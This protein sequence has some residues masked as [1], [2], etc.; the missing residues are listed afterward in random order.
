MTPATATPSRLSAPAFLRP[1]ALVAAPGPLRLRTLVNL[2][3]LAVA[4]QLLALLIVA[5]GFG[6]DFPLA[7]SLAVVAVSVW[8]NTFLSIRHRSARRLS[9]RAAAG[10]LAYDMLQLSA[11][12]FLTGGLENPFAL[13]FLVPPT[14]S[15]TI[16]SLRAT[17]ALGAL[18]IACVTLLAF[19]HLPLPWHGVPPLRL[20]WL[21]VAGIWTALVLGIIF[22]AGYAWRVAAEARRMS[23][24]LIAAQDALARELRLSAL[25]GLAAAAAHE[26]GTPLATISVVAKELQRELPESGPLAEDLRLLREQ[27]ERCRA[28]LARLARAPDQDGA[29][30]TASLAVLIEETAAPHRGRG[31]TIEIETAPAEPA[32]GGEPQ[33]PRAPELLHGLGNLIENAVDF[34]RRR[35]VLR[36]SWDRQ[37][38]RLDIVD[39]GPGFPMSVMDNLG[40]PYVTTRRVGRGEDVD[41]ASAGMGLGVFIAKTLLERTG[42][43]IDFANV[44]EGGAR[45]TVIWL[46]HMIEASR[47]QGRAAE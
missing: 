20:P 26:L 4:G 43:R 32:A 22:L 37:R 6:Y 34:A 16:L 8:L 29:L 24:A 28:I 47:E 14:I 21:Y 11:L 45:V 9:E 41:D 2:R 30:A 38:I 19:Y 15:A 10:F 35:V 17:L 27:A 31:K 36:G 12:L 40:E 1:E 3:W 44:P 25:G 18:T 13:L 5:L 46:R 39:D 33:L 7:P 42:A 23:G